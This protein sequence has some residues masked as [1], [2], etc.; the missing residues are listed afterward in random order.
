MS[1][2]YFKHV[3]FD[4]W[5][6]SC[7]HYEKPESEPP[8]DECL[9]VPAREGSHKPEYWTSKDGNKYSDQSIC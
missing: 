4:K 1:E 6:E 5:C 2:L 9:D 8:C 3:E 7:K